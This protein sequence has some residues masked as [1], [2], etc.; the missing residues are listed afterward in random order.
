MYHDLSRK[1]NG[2]TVTFIMSI[3]GCEV[4]YMLKSKTRV[5][6]VEFNSQSYFN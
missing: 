5:Y 1:A 6:L 4:K 3:M 2:K